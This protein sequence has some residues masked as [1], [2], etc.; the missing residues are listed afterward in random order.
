MLR[1]LLKHPALEIARFA[2]V[3]G[4]ATLLHAI[5]GFVAV[6]SFGLGGMVANA[7]GFGCAWWVSFFGHHIFTFQGRARGRQAFVR[8][9]LHSCMMFLIAQLVIA[10][11][12][13]HFVSLP[14]RFVPLVG[15]IIVPAISF[16]SS[17]FFVFRRA[18]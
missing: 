17:K 6:A 11:L 1:K 14:D 3:G 5:T 10:G 8:F 15:A 2:M 16:L 13:T 12:A 9:V 7:I 18:L 4:A